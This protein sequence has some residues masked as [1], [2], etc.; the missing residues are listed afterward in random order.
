MNT[1][2]SRPTIKDVARVANVS[3]STVSYILNQAPA[4]ERI[5]EQTKQRVWL[6]AERLGY[7]LNPIG[8]ALQRGYTSEVTLLI[9]SW[10]LATSHS[11]TAMAISRAAARLDLALTVHVADDDASAEAF[12][13]RGAFHSGAGLMV[14]WDA[15]AFAESSLMRIAREG[16]PVIDL[17]PD[18]PKG[19][20]TVTADREDAG[21]RGTRLLIEL[22]HRNIGFIGDAVARPKTTLRKLAGY[23]R[24]LEGA[25][26][27]FDEAFL[28][29]VAEF[30]F[31]GGR[32]GVGELLK[33][34]PSITGLFCINDGIALGAMDAA[35]ELGRACPREL[36]IVG[37]GDSS[38]GRYWRP[39]LTTI[40]LS[41]EKVASEALSLVL[42][43]RAHP[44]APPKQVL[45]PERLI[46]RNS[47]GPAPG[48]H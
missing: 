31:E 18:S 16:L 20:S 45:I 40:A 36:S 9:V 1:Q 41:S 24:A 25:G 39:N 6:A 14:L 22:G 38:E 8:R 26:I 17:L 48:V 13:R 27:R 46:I 43:R 12:I 32:R 23:C 29:N 47:T 15:P 21:L 37:F 10:N 44:D 34:C 3:Q 2:S 11:A 7:R 33:R 19:I 4:A 30:G 28:Q 35:S 42:D 5:S